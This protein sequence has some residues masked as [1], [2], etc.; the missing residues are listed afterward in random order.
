[1][2][3]AKPPTPSTD[4]EAQSWQHLQDLLFHD[5]WDARLGR[6]R[7]PFVYRGMRSFGYKLSTSLQRLSG[8]YQ[9]LEHHLLRNFR[10]YAR[11]TTTPPSATVWDWL[12]LAQHHGLPTRLLD[13]TY[14]P[15]VA[16]H[17]VTDD[18][19]AYHQDGII[20]ALNYVKAAEH[21]PP[22]LRGA[23]ASEG[24]N[25]FTSELL[26][27][28]VPSLRA[29]E[30]LQP[31]P[32][33]LFLEPPSLDARIVHQYALFSLMSTSQA[34][35]HTWLA[36][37]PELYFRIRIP[38][39]LKWEIRDKLDQANITER[40]LMPGLG[41]LSRWLHR[42]YSPARGRSATGEGSELPG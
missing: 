35:L 19:H 25:V 41:G 21:L 30:D 8:E 4:F 23:L 12:A 29:L 26:A 20:W 6:Y 27:P 36:A 38:A 17:F 33:V 42:H 16:L 13:W 24:S 22:A 28:A 40:V 9:H 34:M 10:K 7:S 15:Y 1:M 2:S 32:F 37:R 11:D 39:R 14:S 5:T 3:H 18:L 31:E